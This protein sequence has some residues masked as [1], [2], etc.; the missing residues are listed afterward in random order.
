MSND[1]KDKNAGKLLSEAEAN[2]MKEAVKQHSLAKV[3]EAC[4]IGEQS[5]TKAI[6]GIPVQR[7]TVSLVRDFLRK[8]AAVQPSA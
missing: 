8:S 2:T 3:A 7:G 6:A 4:E 1:N 5:L